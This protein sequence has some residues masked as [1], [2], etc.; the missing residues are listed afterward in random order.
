MWKGGVIGDISLHDEGVPTISNILAHW[1]FIRGVALFSTKL[2]AA[3]LVFSL[4]FI[5]VEIAAYP[6]VSKAI[7]NSTKSS[8]SVVKFPGLSSLGVVKVSL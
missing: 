5:A 2:E 1:A 6:P 8:I 3:L 4:I 7:M